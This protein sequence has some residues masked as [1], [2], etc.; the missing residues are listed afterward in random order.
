ML[1][2]TASAGLP[3][4]LAG[5]FREE[6][7]LCRVQPGDL[8][9]A[10]TDARSDASY[11]AATFSAAS[12]LG[13]DVL[14]V[15]VPSTWTDTQADRVVERVRG[16]TLVIDLARNPV[17]FLYSEALSRLLKTG[18]RV[19][20]I[21]GTEAMLRR[22]FPA[23]PQRQ[24]VA[25]GAS[26]LAAGGSVRVTSAAGTDLRLETAGHHVTAQ[27]GV[28]D[29]PGAWDNW[30]GAFLYTTPVY[31]SARGSFVLDRGDVILTLNRYVQDPVRITVEGGRAICVEGGIDAS[32]LEEW[33]ATRDDPDAYCP[34]HIGWGCDER[35]PWSSLAA[36]GV[37][38]GPMDIR[39]AYGNTQLAFGANYG[40]GGQNR[41]RGVT[42]HIDLVSRACSFWVDDRLIVDKGKIVA[43]G[44]G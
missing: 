24:R 40:I 22:V 6:L 42:S 20:K 30:A 2:A 10:Y 34:A 19:L 5:L 21:L 17:L 32:L 23:E 18:T 36:N 16:A 31:G 7:R 15:N 39:A 33:L 9:I 43:E 8:V 3:I 14:Q 12:D 44:L 27:D 29:E 37:P 35:A 1:R 26:A 28:A 25:A 4:D 13:A 41:L 11:V 38:D